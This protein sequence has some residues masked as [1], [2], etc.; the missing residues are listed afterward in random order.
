M[1]LRL[2]DDEQ[3]SMLAKAENELAKAEREFKRQER[4]FTQ[5]LIS[6]Q[7][8]NDANYDLEQTHIS[9][10]DARRELGYTEVNAPIAGTVTARMINL[11]DQVQ[12]EQH[13]FDIVDFDSIVARIFVPERHLDDLRRGSE[14]V[15]ISSAGL[16]ES[17]VHDVIVTKEAPNYRLE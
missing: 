17:H 5:E 4:L 13:L 3:R 10:E 12:M 9:L 1:L 6:E 8:Y 2:Q 15:R 14:F 11:G 7:A 16:H